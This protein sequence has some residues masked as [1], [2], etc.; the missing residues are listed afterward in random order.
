MSDKFG[1]RLG[2]W[3]ARVIGPKNA[4][5][6]RDSADAL[7]SEYEAGKKEAEDPEPRRIPH[8]EIPPEGEA[9]SD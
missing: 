3:V 1:V 7:R 2:R 4:K 8:R 5:K 6:I 9:S